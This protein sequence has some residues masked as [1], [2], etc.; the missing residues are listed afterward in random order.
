M[1][2]NQL[3][4]IVRFQHQGVLIETLDA[5]REL[6][7][8]QKV[9]GDRTLFLA[10]IIQKTVLYVLRWFIHMKFRGPVKV[11]HRQGT[12]HCNAVLTRYLPPHP[13]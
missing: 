9:D 3:L 11:T 2:E 5:A 1:L 6:N 7:A 12:Q 8:A 13:S 10:R 4:L